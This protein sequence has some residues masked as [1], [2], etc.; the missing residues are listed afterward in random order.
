M[1]RPYRQ[2]DLKTLF[3]RVRRTWPR[4]A[5][6]TT[7]MVGFPGE[8][9]GDFQELQ[10]FIEE[11]E[12]DHLGVFRYSPEEGTPANLLP[13]KVAKKMMTKRYNQLLARQKKISQ[14]HNRDFIGRVEP[15][16]ITGP[17]SESEWLLEGR[18]RFQ[19]PEV[20]GVVYITDGNPRIGEINAVKI[21]EA[22]PYDLVGVAL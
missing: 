1:N 5:L 16:L 8:E 10:H 9:E 17:S 2:R 20:D 19:A 6:R 15:V 21:I 13:G 14:A 7:V 12:F 22:H 11:I 4:V 3:R 18:T